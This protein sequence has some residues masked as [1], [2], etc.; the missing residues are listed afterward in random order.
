MDSVRRGIAV[1]EERRGDAG[2][3]APGGLQDDF[4]DDEY[5]SDEPT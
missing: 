3:G 1:L 2:L 5:G 4:G